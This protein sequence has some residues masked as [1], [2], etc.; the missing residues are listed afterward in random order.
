VKDLKKTENDLFSESAAEG[1]PFG[2]SLQE[3]VEALVALLKSF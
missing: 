2:L 3:L 1:S